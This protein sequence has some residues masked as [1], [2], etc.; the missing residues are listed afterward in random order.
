[1]LD[2][3]EKKE[4][5]FKS[6]HR[7]QSEEIFGLGGIEEFHHLDLV[8]NLGSGRDER[9]ATHLPEGKLWLEE[10]AGELPLLHGQ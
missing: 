3:S 5:N 6:T 2:T 1:M 9:G 8:Q 10:E 4:A 7:L